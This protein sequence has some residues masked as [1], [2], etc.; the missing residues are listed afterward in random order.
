M[1]LYL[2]GNSVRVDR[3]DIPKYIPL[4]SWIS[5]IFRY[6]PRSS[7]AFFSA[8]SHLVMEVLLTDSVSLW[9]GVSVVAT[10]CTASLYF[11]RRL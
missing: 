8:A 3:K 7:M 6:S 1:V 2:D 9:N 4:L 10:P 11:L 5:Y